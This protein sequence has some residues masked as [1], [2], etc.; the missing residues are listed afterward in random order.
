MCMS[1]AWPC[2]ASHTVKRTA[3]SSMVLLCSIFVVTGTLKVCR[4]SRARCA[5][6]NARTESLSLSTPEVSSVMARNPGPRLPIKRR[7]ASRDGAVPTTP[8]LATAT[9]VVLSKLSPGKGRCASATPIS[10]PGG[11]TTPALRQHKRRSPSAPDSV[12]PA[13]PAS[14]SASFAVCCIAALSTTGRR[15]RQT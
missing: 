2:V 11:R 10:I 5:R 9:P 4:A 6:S 14:V 12:L 13:N 7:A 3:R 15:S 8:R 1:P